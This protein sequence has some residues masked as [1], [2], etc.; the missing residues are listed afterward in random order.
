MAIPTQ[1]GPLTA[2][3]MFVPE[4]TAFTVPSSGTV[5]KTS[6]PGAGDTS[7]ASG[8][9][10]YID[11]FTIKPSSE[12]AEVKGGNPGGRTLVDVV[13]IEKKHVFT[14][15][16]Q[17]V[18]PLFLQM[19]FGT[20]ALT[21]ASTQANPLEGKLLVK[22]WLKFQCYDV[23]SVLRL[24]GDYWVGLRVTDH[25]AMS[26]GGLVMATYEATGLFSQYNTLTFSS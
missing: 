17:Q 22:G 5:S 11:E 2:H 7:W 13:E 21:S 3:V 26:G 12:V 8:N 19:V 23:D 16:Q 9:M 4:G 1:I 14:F 18:D 10:G 25:D 6:K 20:L 24:V 15:K